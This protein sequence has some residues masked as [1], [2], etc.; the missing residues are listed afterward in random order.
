M[1]G[2][3]PMITRFYAGIGSRRTPAN[4]C[5]LM[6]Q[7]GQKLALKGMILRSGA[8]EGADKA[9][10]EGCDNVQGAKQIFQMSSWYERNP[11]IIKT[12]CFTN[13]YLDEWEK[14]A[15]ITAQNHP[16][17]LYLKPYTKRLHTRNCFQVLGWNLQEPAEFLLCWTADGARTAA[18]TSKDTGGTGQAI[19][20]AS[21]YGIR[22]Y[23]FAVKEDLDLAQSWID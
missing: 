9:F 11:A 18:E 1:R 6:Q 7:L 2:A 8:A 13:A 19:R 21:N 22:V 14:A 12:K 5:E 20:I 4:I 16:S 23:N 15:Q 3:K 17:Y 10:E